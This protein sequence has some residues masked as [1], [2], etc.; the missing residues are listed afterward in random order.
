MQSSQLHLTQTTAK[1]L[2]SAVSNSVKN[3]LNYFSLLM[4]IL[5]IC[6]YMHEG[7]L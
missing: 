1:S 5:L 6:L 7:I 3:N 4:H 2:I